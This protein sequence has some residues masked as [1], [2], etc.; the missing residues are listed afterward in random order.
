M[1][2]NE[3]FQEFAEAFV[4][5]VIGEGDIAFPTKLRRGKLDFSLRVC[6]KSTN[7]SPT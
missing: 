1:E 5:R 4:G 3:I 7:T 6:A 2:L